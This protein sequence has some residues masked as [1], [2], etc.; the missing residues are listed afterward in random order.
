MRPGER[1]RGPPGNLEYG[2]AGPGKQSDSGGSGFR[3][4]SAKRSGP[5]RCTALAS[6]VPEASRDPLSQSLPAHL[7]V[8][9]D[10]VLLSGL[11]AV[12]IRLDDSSPDGAQVENPPADAPVFAR[13][14]SS[15]HGILHVEVGDSV[16]PRAPMPWFVLVQEPR[17]ARP[18]VNLVAFASSHF[19]PGTVL[20]DAEFARLGIRS[21]GQVAA[22]RWYPHGGLVHQ[23][24]VAKPWRGRQLATHLLAA[25]EAVHHSHGWPGWL[26]ADGRLTE[27]GQRMLTR[28]RHPQRFAP[29]REVMP[30]MD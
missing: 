24:Y 15:L 4:H 12:T 9:V 7:I 30:P 5:L 18:A 22:V 16:A 25:A 28:S 20:A 27:L 23:V 26:H 6:G 11:L 1:A 17:A 14:V 2:A 10:R 3:G 21:E 8:T 29:L 13:T 19:P